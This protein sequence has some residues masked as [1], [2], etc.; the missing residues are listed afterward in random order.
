MIGGNPGY[1]IKD[2]KKLRCGFTTGSCA[3]GAAK[4]A[5]MM[6]RGEEPDSVEIDTPAGVLLKL[7]ISSRRMEKDQA[8]CS[9]IKD[10][11]DDPDVTD[12][13]EIFARVRK[14]Q[15]GRVL[16]TGGEGIGIITRKGFFG[17][18]GEYAIN[19][20]PREMIRSE[21]KKVGDF[22]YDVE[23]FAPEGVEKG[24]RTFNE[25]IGIQ[26][27][28]SIIGST[29]IVQP[30]SE[31][32]LLDT[33]FLE[34]DQIKL[35]HGTNGLLLVPGNH[36]EKIARK[37]G[38]NLPSV[39]MSNY[40]GESIQYAYGI[41][42]RSM[43]ILGHV[44][45]LSKLSIGAFNTHSRICDIRLEAF[46]YHLALMETPIGFLN[47]VEKCLT[48]EEALHLCLDHG[49]GQVA[50]K[51][52]SSAEERIRRYLKDDGIEIKVTIYSME[53]GVCP[54]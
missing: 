52:E 5:A 46:I 16:I 11:G 41:G 17:E 38:I 30:M 36:G 23:I 14:R 18:V 40:V 12:G 27:G 48:A 50:R 35:D 19:K 1:V 2:G 31:K 9:I 49:Y 37:E 21:L 24:K 3:A 26:G 39:K 25:N 47:Q 44:G 20:V 42:F 29:G 6:L 53:R 4:A 15:D 7:V 22:G 10:A 54:C 13:I 51:M 32:A 45:K 8:V 28:I 34:M 43:T 33:I